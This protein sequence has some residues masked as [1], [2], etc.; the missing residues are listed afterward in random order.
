MITALD[1]ATIA[2]ENTDFFNV[3]YE[4]SIIKRNKKIHFEKI[5]EFKGIYYISDFTLYQHNAPY[6][7]ERKII[8]L[9]DK[10]LIKSNINF[11]DT[12]IIMTNN[13]LARIGPLEF[14]NF[15]RNF[16]RALIVI[17]DY[18]NHHWY[19]LSILSAIIADIY[20]PAHISN[21]AVQA[22]INPNIDITIPCGSIQWSPE[23]LFNNLQQ[24]FNL[25]RI[26][27]PLG[28]HNYYEKFKYRNS[29][30]TTLGQKLNS[31]N[32]NVE[33][34][35]TRSPIDRLS[36][37]TNHTCHWIIPVNN[38]LPIR[39]FDALITGGIPIIPSGLIQYMN[40]LG[41]PKDFYVTYEAADI[42]NPK[43]VIDNA[44]YIF[45]KGK[46]QGVIKR[47]NYCFEKFH[48]NSILNTI[49]CHANDK[50]I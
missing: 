18:D 33:N 29:I 6:A 46:T 50:Y 26:K 28:M 43:N 39:F 25:K 7:E 40:F 4:K 8:N 15:I 3:Y 24:I 9:S 31:V 47:F 41:I 5:K 11:N 13:N 30:A 16:E 17:H 36:E 2:L 20:I 14:I 49:I 48:Y 44:N 42:I 19:Q 35:H 22:R 34:F 38:D 12:L 27:Q 37:W 45:E 1:G 21:N 32:L 23:L 10:D